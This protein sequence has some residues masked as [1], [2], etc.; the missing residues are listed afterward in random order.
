MLSS[1]LLPTI[2]NRTIITDQFPFDR[3][4]EWSNSVEEITLQV[5]SLNPF[6]AIFIGLC[7]CYC[8]AVKRKLHGAGARLGQFGKTLKIR[9]KINPEFHL[10]SCDYI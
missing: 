1:R 9:V 2:D 3:R 7:S 6:F 5:P 10:A 4:K 8:Q